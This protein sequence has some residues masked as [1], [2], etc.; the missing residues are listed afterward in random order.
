MPKFLDTPQWYGTDGSE[1]QLWSEGGMSGQYLV[2][3][4]DVPT[5]SSLR[6]KVYYHWLYFY[7][8]PDG[9]SV[10]GQGMLYTFNNNP[11]DYTTVTT[12]PTPCWAI[13]VKSA[14]QN[15]YPT[16][17]VK[18][19]TS[20]TIVM[21]FVKWGADETIKTINTTTFRSVQVI[22]YGTTLFNVATT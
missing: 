6:P 17:R 14:G 5:W 13:A 16:T 15:E 19:K 8:I 18:S 11:N 2:L 4:N 9:E 7:G 12:F 20:T 21:E 3:V 10:M 22:S 1:Q